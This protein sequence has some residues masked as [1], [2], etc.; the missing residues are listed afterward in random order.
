MSQAA[1]LIVM[2]LFLILAF[3]DDILAAIKYAKSQ[4]YNIHNQYQTHTHIPA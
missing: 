1:I 2:L 4:L 3:S